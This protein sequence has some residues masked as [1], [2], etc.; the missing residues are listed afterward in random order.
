MLH[1]IAGYS[2]MYEYLLSLDSMNSSAKKDDVLEL[3]HSQFNIAYTTSFDA[4]V[5]GA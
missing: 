4:L 1:N 3:P 2:T 5:F